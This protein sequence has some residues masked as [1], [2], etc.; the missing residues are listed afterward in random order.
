MKMV[1]Q[2]VIGTTYMTGFEQ[3]SLKEGEVVMI[4]S[5]KDSEILFAEVPKGK[6]WTV[7]IS[8]EVYELNAS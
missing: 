7:S 2:Q 1:T 3:V 5:P 8:V 6:Q 4:N